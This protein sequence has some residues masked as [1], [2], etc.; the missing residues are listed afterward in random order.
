M[1][2]SDLEGFT[3]ERMNVYIVWRP[4]V[5]YTTWAN[6]FFYLWQQQIFFRDQW[7]SQL[8]SSSF[9]MSSLPSTIFFFRLDALYSLWI[10][11]D[12]LSAFFLLKRQFVCVH[13]YFLLLIY[14]FGSYEL[15]KTAAKRK[16]KLH[17]CIHTH[18]WMAIQSAKCCS[19]EWGRRHACLIFSLWCRG[20]GH[21]EQREAD[22]SNQSCLFWQQIHSVIC[23]QLEENERRIMK[24]N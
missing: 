19:D 24:P 2:W 16:E 5:L 13:F 20:C 23:S 10:P 6:I 9:L 8:L 3:C 4:N 1:L 17:L 18:T 15:D 7:A 12:G 22:Q 11:M 21:P 14:G